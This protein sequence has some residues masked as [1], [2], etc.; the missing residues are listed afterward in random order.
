MPYDYVKSTLTEVN[1][2]RSLKS[3]LMTQDREVRILLIGY[4]LHASKAYGPQIERLQSTGRKV[5]LVGVV[6]IAGAEGGVRSRLERLNTPP[7]SYFIEPFID[8]TLPV[9]AEA[10]LN[11]LVDSLN[12]NA[13][14]VGTI[15]ECH[16]AFVEWALKRDLSVMVDKPYTT[17]RNAVSDIKAARGI[18][19][20]LV[21]T[22]KV[23]KEALKR[24]PDICATMLVQRRYMPAHNWI[25]QSVAEVAERFGCPVTYISGHHE[26]GQFRLPDELL[27]IDYHGY[28]PGNG[29]ISHSGEHLFDMVQYWTSAGWTEDTKPD[30]TKVCASFTQP[31]AFLSHIPD[32]AYE[33]M[34]GDAWTDGQAFDRAAVKSVADRLGEMDAS[35]MLEFERNGRIISRADISLLHNSVSQRHWLR[36]NADLYKQSGRIKA[37]KWQVVC[38]PFQSIS[39][40]TRQ[41]DDQHEKSGVKSSEPG[42]PN[43]MQIIRVRNAGL[44]G[45]PKIEVLQAHDLSPNHDETRRH[46]EQAK[47]KSLE[48]F[49]D[50]LTGRIA[51]EDMKSE[52]TQ[53]L[54][55]ARWLSATYVSHNLKTKGRNRFVTLR[56]PAQA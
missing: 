1:G 17:R 56:E 55:T 47:S 27:G 3:C 11:R 49:L 50:F 15:P 31:D 32:H 41:A 2:K 12:A 13:V 21:S 53:H 44:M 18:E 26:D 20:D 35:V 42:G 36:P 28:N 8:D 33:K 38:G 14:I 9:K 30:C 40:E 4:G 45:G 10:Q 25:R 19:T 7:P 34:F 48:E 46:G 16:R 29:K 22:L 6:D 43:H 39:V 52:L 37:E 5:N 24:N 23:Y 51:R 54:T